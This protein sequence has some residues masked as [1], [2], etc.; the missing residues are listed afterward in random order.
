[1]RQNRLQ[2][3]FSLICHP[4]N[5]HGRL[6]PPDTCRVG[7][8]VT[9]VPGWTRG[10]RP[11]KDDRAAN[12]HRTGDKFWQLRPRPRGG[13]SSLYR[14]RPAIMKSHLNE[15]LTLTLINL[16]LTITRCI[17]SK[18]AFVLVGFRYS[19]M[20]PPSASVARVWRY[21]NLFITII[22][23]IITI[24]RYRFWRSSHTI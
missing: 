7:V 20:F 6:T 22:I 14:N 12:W 16:N 18:S 11:L 1:M 10:G 19:G 3:T 21:R 23:T 5:V 15:S 24:Q 9:A 4:Q 2:D 17:R 13:T 8:E